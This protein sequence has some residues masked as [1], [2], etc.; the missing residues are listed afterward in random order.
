MTYFLKLW[1]L[2][3]HAPTSRPFIGSETSK[4]QELTYGS[5]STVNGFNRQDVSQRSSRDALNEVCNCIFKIPLNLNGKCSESRSELYDERQS[6]TVGYPSH[7]NFSAMQGVFQKEGRFY[8]TSAASSK[9][10]HK[11]AKRPRKQAL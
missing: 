3:G 4:I 7:P 10:A 2:T 6:A 9:V 1:I 5:F 8:V 11:K